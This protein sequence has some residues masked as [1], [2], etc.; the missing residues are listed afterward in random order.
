[1]LDIA[2]AQTTQ[3]PRAP[4]IFEAFV[5][6]LLLILPIFWFLLIR[7]QQRKVKAHQE[8][9]SKLKK[10]DE[11]MTTGGIYGKVVALGD[12]VITI[13]IAPNVRIRVNRGQISQLVKVE[14]APAKEGK[15][16]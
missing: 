5:I 12:H 16:Q 1:M 10:N 14:K 8:M 9:L 15:E 2:F 4:G 11:V 6:P 3:Q 13:E 7:P